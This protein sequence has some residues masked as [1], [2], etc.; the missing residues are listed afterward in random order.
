MKIL[1]RKIKS[2]NSVSK[3]IFEFVSVNH[4]KTQ[5]NY[6]KRMLDNKVFCMKKAKKYDFDYW[7]GNRRFGYGGYKYINGYFKDLA[8]KIIKRYNLNN[9]SKILDVGC[10]K[11]YLLFEIKK[12]LKKI[13]ILGIDISS[14]A[15]NNSK[16]EIK[17]FL[18]KKNIE[19]GLDFEDNYFDLV[20]SINTLHNLKLKELEKSILEIE[21]LGKQKF[22][23]V[24][25][26]R[27]EME[28]FNVQCWAL[29][30]ETLIDK[31][32]WEWFLKKC[33]YT[34]NYEFIYF[35]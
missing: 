16:K 34:G 11:G 28:Q 17:K 21:R 10:G 25:S 13:T 12:I 9:D 4:L 24:E 6:L 31:S 27:N 29:T 33:S 30:A 26:Y 3:E 15:I 20:L 5:R 8:K 35:N 22:I 7:D 23:C 32:S 19:K 1:H 14:Y 2:K 18:I